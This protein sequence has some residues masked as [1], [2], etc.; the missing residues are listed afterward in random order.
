MYSICALASKDKPLDEERRE[1]LT[2]A[3][4]PNQWKWL[5]R[6]R[7]LVMRFRSAPAGVQIIA[8]RESAEVDLFFK[9]DE[10]PFAPKKLLICDMDSTV[11]EQEC[12]DELADFAGFREK[13]VGITEAAMRGELD[14]EAALR[15]RVALLKGLPEA[16]MQQVFDERLTLS[17]GIEWLVKGMKREGAKAILVSGGFVFFTERVARRA[18]FEEHYGNRLAVENGVLTG[19]IVAPVLTKDSKLKILE[20]KINQLGITSEDVLAIGDGANDIPMLQ[21]A[22]MGVAYRAK[23]ATKKAAKFS[24]DFADHET[25]L[26]AQGI[27]STA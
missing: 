9:K 1:L 20:H 19:E 17:E 27:K 23:A 2:S 11:I 15:E 18:G 25:L 4:A 7:A 13:V 5:R 21:H 3:L 12:I 16:T 10:G 8:A 6:N 22:G 14:F 26:W 24:L